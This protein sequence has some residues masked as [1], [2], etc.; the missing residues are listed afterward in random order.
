[1]KTKNVHKPKLD[2]NDKTIISLIAK[3]KEITPELLHYLLKQNNHNIP[4]NELE[5]ILEKLTDQNYLQYNNKRLG[6][7][8]YRY[9]STTR[10]HEEK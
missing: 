4:K 2:V 5:N 6:K 1:V 8:I 9:Y 3:E 10:K 7:N